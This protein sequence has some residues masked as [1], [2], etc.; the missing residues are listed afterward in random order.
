MEPNTETKEFSIECSGKKFGKM[1]IQKNIRTSKNKETKEI[2]TEEEIVLV[3]K[4]DPD[5]MLDPRCIV[6]GND[7]IRFFFNVRK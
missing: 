1:M 2:T 3:V 6:C 7:E 4:I 5:S